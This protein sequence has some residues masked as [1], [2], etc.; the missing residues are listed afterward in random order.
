MF[1][2]VE[3]AAIYNSC[4]RGR[5]YTNYINDSFNKNSDIFNGLDNIGLIYVVCEIYTLQTIIVQVCRA[6]YSRNL[7]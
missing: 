1:N 6:F 3:G 7:F 2:K 4:K 5:A